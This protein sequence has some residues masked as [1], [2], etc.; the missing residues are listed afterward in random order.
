MSAGRK[1]KYDTKVVL[2]DLK[3]RGCVITEDV[4]NVSGARL[5]NKAW[6]MI[7]FLVNHH[8][9]KVGFTDEAA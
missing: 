8:K 3:R 5:G 9:Y 2:E 7:D 6:G 1:R 4:I